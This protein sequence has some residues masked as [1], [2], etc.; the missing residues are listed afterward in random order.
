MDL[1]SVQTTI[2]IQICFLAKLLKQM[3]EKQIE[4]LRIARATRALLQCGVSS[5]SSLIQSCLDYIRRRQMEDG[6][7]TCLFDTCD[8]I[9]VFDLV[10]EDF[11]VEQA[12]NWLESWQAPDGGW[13]QFPRDISRLPTTCIA[14]CTL[15]TVHRGS[16]DSWARAEAFI[17]ST[18]LQDLAQGGLTYKG[19]YFLM[20]AS[21]FPNKASHLPLVDATIKWLTHSQE[22]N[23]GFAPTHGHVAGPSVSITAIVLDGLLCWVDRVPQPVIDCAVE[24]ILNRQI[25]G[26]GWP[27]HELDEVSSLALPCLRRLLEEMDNDS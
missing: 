26:G 1:I 7:W 8:S 14:L 11:I 5:S 13:G 6:G 16:R 9:E 2:E 21:H 18:W 4:C 10:E 17:C 20:A 15:Y 23:G 24:F 22:S 25:P 3:Y 19:G 12:V 27:E